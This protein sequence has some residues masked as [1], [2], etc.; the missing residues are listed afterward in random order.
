MALMVLLYDCP[1]VPLGSVDGFS[2]I[3][4][5]WV[6]VDV[7][8]GVGVGVGD[9]AGATEIITCAVF[10][11]CAPRES[12]TVSRAGKLP[13]AVYVCAIVGVDCVTAGEPS[14]KLNVYE[15]MV[16][17]GG[18][19]SGSNEP[20]PLRA[21]DNGA[22]PWVGVAVKTAIGGVLGRQ[23]WLSLTT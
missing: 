5:Q 20:E 21:T 22:V 9:A 13:A 4:G 10:V 15:A 1:T 3:V 2:V 6:G 17:A 12:V 8:V 7:G 16:S 18:S 23:T 14:P 19:V 11:L